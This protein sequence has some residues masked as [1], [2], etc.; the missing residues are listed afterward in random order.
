MVEPLE[1]L[2][3]WRHESIFNDWAQISAT[4]FALSKGVGPSQ[5]P[6][7]YPVAF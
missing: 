7:T 4:A 1:P 3:P 5:E 6:T 2:A